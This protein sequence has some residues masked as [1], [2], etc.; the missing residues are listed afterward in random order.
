MVKTQ[1]T[2]GEVTSLC[3]TIIYQKITV[4][5]RFF[6]GGGGWY[7]N[8]R[9]HLDLEKLRVK[10]VQLDKNLTVSYGN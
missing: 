10:F 8:T 1:P 9:N 6:F 7:S 2:L 5:F 3:Y 4:S